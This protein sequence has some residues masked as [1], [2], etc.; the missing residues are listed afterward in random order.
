MFLLT[1][2]YENPPSHGPEQIPGA[3][4]EGLC[5]LFEIRQLLDDA[6]GA[7]PSDVEPVEW[8]HSARWWGNPS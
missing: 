1:S 2:P 5:R 4:R 3:F 7:A 8:F 6:E